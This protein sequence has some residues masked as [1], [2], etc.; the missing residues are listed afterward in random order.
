[1]KER[2]EMGKKKVF[3]RWQKKKLARET[4]SQKEAILRRL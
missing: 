2:V 1:M 4:F 3:A